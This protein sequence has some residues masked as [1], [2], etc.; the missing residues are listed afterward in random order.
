[1]VQKVFRIASLKDRDLGS[2]EKRDIGRLAHRN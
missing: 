2:F 1:M